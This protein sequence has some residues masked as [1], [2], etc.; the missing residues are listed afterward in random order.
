MNIIGGVVRPD[1]GT[2]RL[3]GAPY[4]PRDPGD[5]AGNRIAFIHQELNLFTNLTIAENIFLDG[6][7]RGVASGRWR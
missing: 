6:I 2:M 4:A 5:A 1:G 3:D 7:S